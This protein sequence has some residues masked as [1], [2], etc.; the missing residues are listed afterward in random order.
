M[1][2]TFKLP[3]ADC[4]QNT[5]EGSVHAWLYTYVPQLRQKKWMATG[6]EEV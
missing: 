1:P 2:S 6:T 4:L 3:L 5:H